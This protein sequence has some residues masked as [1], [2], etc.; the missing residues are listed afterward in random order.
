M[1]LRGGVCDDEAISL[2]LLI[3]MGL[4]RRYAPRNDN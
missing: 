3:T 4:L 1:S 2:F